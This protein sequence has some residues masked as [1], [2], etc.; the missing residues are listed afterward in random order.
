MHE[1]YVLF[2]RT[3][4]GWNFEVCIYCRWHLAATSLADRWDL[5]ATLIGEKNALPQS[6]ALFFW[7]VQI[8]RLSPCGSSVTRPW[9]VLDFRK[10]FCGPFVS[11]KGGDQEDGNIEMGLKYVEKQLRVLRIVRVC[12]KDSNP[13]RSKERIVEFSDTQ[14]TWVGSG[15]STCRVHLPF[16]WWRC[17]HGLLGGRLDHT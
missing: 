13:Q 3:P 9:E 16:L 15:S 14:L 5:A 12:K 2:L 17:S 11:S 1:H 4:A 8:G 7:G 10:L 6:P